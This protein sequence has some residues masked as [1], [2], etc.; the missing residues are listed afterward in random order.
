[1]LDMNQRRRFFAE[2][3]EAIANLKTPGLIDALSTI[4]RGAFLRPGPWL[5]LGEGDLAG[6]PRQTP[7]AAPRHIYHNLA[8]GIDPARRLF[9]GGPATV[10]TMIDALALAPGDRVLHVGCGL[11]YYTA[12]MAHVVGANGRVV[13]IEVDET[14]ASEASANLASMP[15]VE[16]RCGDSS[17][18]LGEMFDAILVSA[19][20]THPEETWLSALSADGRLVEP[21]TVAMPAMGATIGK[22]IV[23]LITRARDDSSLGVRVVTFVAIYSAVGLRDEIIGAQLG[24]ALQRNPFPRLTRLRRDAHEES[25]AC[26][27]HTARYCLSTAAGADPVLADLWNKPKDA[28]YDEL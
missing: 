24:R 9:N 4:P 22:G 25:D 3:I 11:G 26:W 20:V 8:V 21:L 6:G 10:A 12:L 19:G 23:T 17:G 2:E 5:V 7:D 15:W 13:G 16:V 18:D 27:I 28:A 1:M 14:L